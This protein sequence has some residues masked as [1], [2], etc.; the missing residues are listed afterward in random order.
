M[1]PFLGCGAMITSIYVLFW[2]I[3]M[4]ENLILRKK[5]LYKLRFQRFGMG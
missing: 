5:F 2:R 1:F 4:S 3:A